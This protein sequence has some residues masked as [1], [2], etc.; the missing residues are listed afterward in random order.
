MLLHLVR[1]AHAVSAEINPHRPLSTKGIAECAQLSQF[2]RA[3][4]QFMPAYLL[5][6]PLL[7]ALETAQF[8]QDSLC[9]E[10][11]LLETPGLEPD[12]DPR[13]TFDELRHRDDPS[14]LALVGH[15][16]HLSLLANLLLHG[17]STPGPIDLEKA[18]VLTLRSLGDRPAQKAPGSWRLLWY[19]HPGLIPAH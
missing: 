16:H 18:G 17:N 6:S 10:A 2:L 14:T 3:N 12:D 5:H 11:L 8:F 4:R 9:P 15:N 7:R 1:H 13:V 19:I